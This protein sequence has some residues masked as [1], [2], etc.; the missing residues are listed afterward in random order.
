MTINPFSL[1]C[2]H[3]HRKWRA[4][5]SRAFRVRTRCWGRI[6]RSRSYSASLPASVQSPACVEARAVPGPAAATAA[7]AAAG[8]AAGF[9]V[10]H[11]LQYARCGAL[12]SVHVGHCQESRADSKKNQNSIQRREKMW[13]NDTRVLLA[14]IMVIH[15]STHR[16]CRINEQPGRTQHIFI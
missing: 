10:W 4:S 1:L 2:P 8:S 5:C 15:M 13:Q 3:R 11:T 14:F 16:L 7:P 9:A 6:T 12:T